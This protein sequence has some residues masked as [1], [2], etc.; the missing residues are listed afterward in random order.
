MFEGMPEQENPL[1]DLLMALM[2]QEGGI[3]N[4]AQPTEPMIVDEMEGSPLVDLSGVEEDPAP[5][6]D[7][8]SQLTKLFA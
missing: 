6:D 8:L 5:Q 1:M 7:V 4:P 3:S 2:G